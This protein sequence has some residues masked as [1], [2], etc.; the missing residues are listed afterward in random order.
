MKKAFQLLSTLS[1]K[2]PPRD[3]AHHSMTLGDDTIWIS[4]ELPNG[5][6]QYALLPAAF[7]WSVERIVMEFELRETARSL[8][9]S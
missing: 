3:G 8:S 6:Q 2:F 9:G 5:R 1:Y 4:L 7:D